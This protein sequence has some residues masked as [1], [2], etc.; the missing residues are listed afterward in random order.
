MPGRHWDTTVTEAIKISRKKETQTKISV[1]SDH[2]SR[3]I[4]RWNVK[5]RSKLQW[6]TCILHPGEEVWLTTCSHPD[7]FKTVTANDS[8][9]PFLLRHNVVMIIHYHIQMRMGKMF[10]L[11]TTTSGSPLQISHPRTQITATDP[12]ILKMLFLSP[13]IQYLLQNWALPRVKTLLTFSLTSI[14]KQLLAICF[15]ANTDPAASRAFP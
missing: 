4:H 14:P 9:S 6:T 8:S 2:N 7:A 15:H 1:I 10:P 12:N 11:Q 5:Q 3:D 13:H